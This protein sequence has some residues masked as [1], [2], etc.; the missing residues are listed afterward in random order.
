M[1]RFQEMTAFVAVV[2][3][4]GFSAAA[5]RL[6][7]SQSAV[8]KAVG[9]LEKRLGVALLHRSTRSV[10]LTDH[11][12]TYY[13][14]TVPLLEEMAQTDAEL[15]STT[16]EPAG[17]VRLATAAT[18]GRLHVL[19]L[20]PLLLK[21]HPGIR[22]D[23]QF[24]DGVRDLLADGV[25][26]AIR[27]S[28]QQHPDAV[29]KRVASTSLVCVGARSYFRRHGLPRTPQDLA[30]HNCLIYNDMRE[31]PFSGPQGHFS[32]PVQGNL[33][34]NTVEAI[35]SAVRAGVGIGLFNRASLV[36]EMRHPDIVTVLD[37]YLSET[38]DVSLV[39][40]RRRF[41]PQRVRVVTEFF[42]T[43]LASRI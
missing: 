21:R 43:E 1:D 29:V 26:L 35:L 40:P 10:T 7:E 6:G 2:E 16:Q 34:A 11:G 5:R 36:G 28:P 24:A 12:R 32:V 9:A 27:I 37:A 22:L 41:I 30:R 8:S 19:P 38:R 18:F 42:A 39:W 3:T 13:A 20:V 31:W 23:L 33:S 17:L 25:D 4:G 15:S 14:R